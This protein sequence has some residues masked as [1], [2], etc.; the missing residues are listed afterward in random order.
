VKKISEKKTAKALTVSY[1]RLSRVQALLRDRKFCDG[2]PQE[3]EPGIV[4]N[5]ENLGSCLTAAAKADMQAVNA[6][7][8][9]RG[10]NRSARCLMFH[11]EQQ[12]FA[13]HSQI[14]M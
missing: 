14:K 10:M 8:P 4:I 13:D 12:P 11:V 1:T 7:Q 6:F 3:T 9:D 5:T 2:L